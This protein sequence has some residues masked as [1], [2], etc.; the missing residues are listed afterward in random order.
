MFVRLSLRLYN[1]YFKHSPDWKK[2]TTDYKLGG[3]AEVDIENG[4]NLSKDRP[5]A[6]RKLRIT[7]FFKENK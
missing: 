4:P 7:F 3:K 2:E 6:S 5:I 1:V